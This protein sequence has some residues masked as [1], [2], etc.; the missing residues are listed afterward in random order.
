LVGVVNLE[1]IIRAP[2]FVVANRH[3]IAGTLASVVDQNLIAVA[4]ALVVFTKERTVG[5]VA[6]ITALNE[7]ALGIPSLETKVIDL[8]MRYS[9]DRDG[10]EK[11]IDQEVSEIHDG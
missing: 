8:G 1:R 10:Q 11:K 5:A 6:W 2:A 3:L 9:L 4:V 7:V